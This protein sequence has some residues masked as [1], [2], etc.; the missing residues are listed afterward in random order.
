V[1]VHPHSASFTQFYTP[2]L[3]LTLEKKVVNIN[4][5]EVTVCIWDTA[6]Q[7]KFFSLTKSYFKKADGVLVVFDLT[8]KVSF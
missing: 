2:T 1:Y 4:G 7:E 3:G 5:Q 6:G 8:D